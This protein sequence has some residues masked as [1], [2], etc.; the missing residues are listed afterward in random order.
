LAATPR[1]LQS[2]IPA[3]VAKKVKVL[4]ITY[5]VLLDTNHQNWRQRT[6]RVWP[7]VYLIDKKGRGRHGWEGELEQ[8]DAGGEAKMTRL[9]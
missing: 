1:K 8:K 5:P 2:R 9:I 7:T 6:Q 4:G 3:K